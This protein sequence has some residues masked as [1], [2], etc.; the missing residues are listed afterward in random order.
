MG[1]PDPLLGLQHPMLLED[2]LRVF[3]PC[4]PLLLQLQRPCWN[5]QALQEHT[6][7]ELDVPADN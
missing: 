7:T 6:G 5:L 4:G 3:Q 2:V 1:L